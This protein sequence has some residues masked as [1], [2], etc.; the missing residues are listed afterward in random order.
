MT[1]IVLKPSARNVAISRE[2]DADRRI[3]RQDRAE[4]PPDGHKAG[5]AETQR[6]DESMSL[7]LDCWS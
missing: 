6:V 5:N 4:Q 1:E 7:F 2:R 3:P